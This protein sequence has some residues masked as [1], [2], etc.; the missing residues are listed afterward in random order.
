MR[1]ARKALGNGISPV[2]CLLARAHHLYHLVFI[3]GISFNSISGAAYG[4]ALKVSY[5]EMKG[6]HSGLMTN[7]AC[8][9][10]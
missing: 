8:M 1:L 5:E 4:K 10:A 9:Q 6:G 3:T 2:N 7:L